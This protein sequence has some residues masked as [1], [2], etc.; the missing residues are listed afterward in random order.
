MKIIVCIKQVPDTTEVRIDPVK[1]T[2]IREGVPA[3]MNP[4]D[5]AGLE[6]A[7]RIKDEM[8][9]EVTVLSMGLPAAEDVIREAMAMGA[10]N[11]Y[12]VTDRCLG[13]ADTWATSCTIAAAIKNLDY[14]L[15]ITGRQA[16]DGDTAQVGPEIAEHLGIPN[17]SYCSELHAEDG[18][19]IAKR[20]FDDGWQVVKAQLP[21]LV[22]VLGDSC[23][24]RYLTPRGIFDSWQNK[25]MILWGRANLPALDDANIGL[26]GSPTNVKASFPK[27]LK[28]KGEIVTVEGDEA[29]SWI[30]SKLHEKLVI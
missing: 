7:L 23:K 18:A 13:G 10:D 9:A 14:D 16:I 6:Y 11:G 27:A 4:D 24:P 29:A 3:I 15:V 30:V 22:T 17:I 12:L 26:A 8:D 20:M 5:K 19:I 25:T 2:L 21:C 1:G 28:G